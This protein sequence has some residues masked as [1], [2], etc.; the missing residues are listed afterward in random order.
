[1]AFARFFWL[2]SKRRRHFLS[3]SPGRLE[4][5]TSPAIVFINALLTDSSPPSTAFLNKHS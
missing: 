5:T 2:C 3:T 1:M 4:K